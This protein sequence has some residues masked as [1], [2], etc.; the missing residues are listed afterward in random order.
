MLAK[1]RPRSIYDVL[2]A[3][4]CFVALGGTSAYAINEWT[5]TNIA[6]ESLTGADVRGKARTSSAAAVNGSLTTD[7]IAGQPAHSPTG[8]PFVD[9]TLTQW[10]IK[11]G[12]VTGSD[13]VESSLA[14]VP[15]A[16]KLD[17][18]DST[19]L[20]PAAGDGRTADLALMGFEPQTVLSAN[21]TTARPASLLATAAVDISH[22]GT[23]AAVV[24]CWLR[25]DTS[26]T[27]PIF[28]TTV[29]GQGHDTLPLVWAQGVGAG[30]HT[31][32]VRCTGPTD[33]VVDDAGMIVSAH[34]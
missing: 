5:G 8:T 1:L 15:D 25:F 7:D 17:N 26:T 24:E 2:A 28:G 4:G 6:D 18:L 23:S 12:S 13:V 22:L 11:N 31:V 30:T 20:S 29:P 3:L 34:M 14:K 9:G 27:S 10:D 19:Q 21:I 16:D 32:E 33:L